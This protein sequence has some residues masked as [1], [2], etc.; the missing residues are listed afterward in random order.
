MPEEA[1][2]GLS[3]LGVRRVRR[4][5]DGEA[6][7]ELEVEQLHTKIGQLT[8]ERDFLAGRSGR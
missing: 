6:A 3:D 1:A 5:R 7:D 2:S 8:V 4:G